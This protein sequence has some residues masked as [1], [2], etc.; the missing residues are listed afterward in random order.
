MPWGENKKKYHN[1]EK[2]GINNKKSKAV[3]GIHKLT[4]EKVE[5]YSISEAERKIGVN[6][7][8]ISACCLKLK[9]KEGGRKDGTQGYYIRQSAGGYTWNFKNA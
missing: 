8:N 7:Q 4:G 2:N 3:I 6:Q 1:D 9:V 5:F